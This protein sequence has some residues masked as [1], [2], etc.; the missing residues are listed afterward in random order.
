MPSQPFEELRRQSE[1]V[2]H[3]I[4]ATVLNSPGLS[5]TEGM[6]IFRDRGYAEES[7]RTAFTEVLK[8]GTIVLQH[9]GNVM[10]V[11]ICDEADR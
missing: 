7:V 4:T 3:Q 8:R 6:G 5:I 2:E 1:V 10:T 11:T 9:P